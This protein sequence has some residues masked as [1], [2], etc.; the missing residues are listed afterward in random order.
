MS[1]CM[2]AKI[3][4]THLNLNFFSYLCTVK[5]TPPM[6]AQTNIF[7]P[8]TP[9]KMPIR[10]DIVGNI[11][12]HTHTHTHTHNYPSL[13]IIAQ[14][15]VNALPTVRKEPLTAVT[16]RAIDR[17]Q[18]LADVSERVIDRSQHLADVSKRVIVRSLSYVPRLASRVPR[19]MSP[20]LCPPSSVPKSNNHLK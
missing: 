13:L 2:S 18:H 12:T 3:C 14:S 8:K 11:F 16:E 1:F 7:P 10:L 9:K 5:T 17:S 6:C 20:V 19:P 15:A 4:Q